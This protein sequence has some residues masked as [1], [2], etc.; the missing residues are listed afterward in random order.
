MQIVNSAVFNNSLPASRHRLVQLAQ[1]SGAVFDSPLFVVQDP[2]DSEIVKGK[3]RN[4][5]FYKSIIGDPNTLPFPEMRLEL[6]PNSSDG[7]TVKVFKFWIHH[8]AG[9]LHMLI[10]PIYIESSIPFG[11]LVKTTELIGES[12]A[13]GMNIYTAV[14]QGEEATLTKDIPDRRLREIAL[15]DIH[16]LMSSLALF[17][18]R[19]SFGSEFIAS[20]RPDKQGKSVEWMKARTHYVLLH[21]SHPA[22]KND[23]ISGAVVSEDK[24]YIKRQAHSR[25]AHFRIL[26]S[27]K[28][29][30]KIGQKIRIRSC[31]VGPKEWKQASS[32]YQLQPTITM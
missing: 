19:V 9:K 2:E 12:G 6:A 30:N 26:R 20:V 31:W 27:A 10:Q 11:F 29:K 13:E 14:F 5:R 1:M 24:E 32:I 25:R 17:W 8:R 22:N 4:S 23:I 3:D 18:E 15:A 7:K 28:F 21:R 16:G